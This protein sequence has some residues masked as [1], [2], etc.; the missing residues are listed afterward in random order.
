MAPGAQNA[1]G[2]TVDRPAGWILWLALAVAW[3]ATLA[4]CPL[5]DPD[6]GRYAEIP[7]EMASSG[8]WVTPRL[9]GL[10]Y[11][12][13]PALQ[14]WATAGAYRLFGVSEWTARLW[15]A[16]LAFLCLPLIFLYTRKQHGPQA[17]PAAV[18][19]LAMSP[20]FTV[21]GHLNLLDASLTFF[22]TAGILAFAL[23]QSAAPAS[24][25]ERI[26][27][28]AAWLAAALAVLSKGI[29]A[30]ALAGGALT[31]YSLLERDTG[32]WR[33]LHLSTGLPL[34]IAVTA[35]WFVIVSL[36]NPEFAGFFFVHE[37][38]TRFLT[39]V[40]EHSGPWWYFI[41]F[42]AFG[43]LPWL[44]STPG[45]VRQ[46]WTETKAPSPFK[47]QKFLLLFA[48]V[49]FTF[50]SVSNSKLAPYILPMFPV[51]AVVI[52]VQV[53]RRQSGIR[54]PALIAVATVALFAAAL[55][56]KSIHHSGAVADAPW[57]WSI[58]ACLYV[59]TAAAIAGALRPRVTLSRKTS[60]V[61]A[62]G[63]V[64]AWQ[65]LTMAYSEIRPTRTAR[66]LA[67]RVAPLV[68]ADT[69]LFSIGQYR[70]TIPPYLG[71]TLK[72]VAYRGEMDFG[73]RQEPRSHVA[74]MEE[75]LDIWR[76]STNAI[77]FSS[78]G[79][80]RDLR[81]MGMQGRVVADDGRSIAVSRW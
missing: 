26:Y 68:S 64:L 45:A 47:P 7:R 79:T 4:V 21:I 32:P 12:E 46:A 67:A 22:L 8:D 51:L 28:L 18:A 66:D 63:S 35:P 54:G 25:S 13:K 74:T 23:A 78:P 24:R 33:R 76:D 71:R 62:I 9:N 69:A 50:Y 55:L 80:Y 31:L 2:S 15:P 10:K 53:A 36:R 57:L 77:A 17:A 19:V 75:F 52:G 5:L 49:T 29:V 44:A 58:L 72:L 48:A 3:F 38:F 42:L 6:E 16:G 1:S 41:P 11:F 30:G 61:L 60:F 81:R 34:F 40:H 20:L 65:C 39:T 43:L 59:L 27:M 70:Q 37:H 14:Y 56:V 73:L